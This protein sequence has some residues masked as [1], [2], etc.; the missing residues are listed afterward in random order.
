MG[1]IHI[2]AEQGHAVPKSVIQPRG[3]FGAYSPTMDPNQE[4]PPEFPYGATAQN[5]MQGVQWFVCN[6]CRAHVPGNR[7]EQHICGEGEY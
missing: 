3:P 4:D 7:L 2:D 5:N 6:A 1:V